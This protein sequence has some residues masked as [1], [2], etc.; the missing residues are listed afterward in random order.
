MSVHSKAAG[1]NRRLRLTAPDST[2]VTHSRGRRTGVAQVRLGLPRTRRRPVRPSN[3][4]P[5]VRRTLILIKVPCSIAAKTSVELTRG[6]RPADHM[7][8]KRTRHRGR[9]LGS[10]TGDARYSEANADA[11]VFAPRNMQATDRP[12]AWSS[13]AIT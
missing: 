7:K 6:R 2:R 3:H 13:Y 12:R 11:V 4:T 8:E 1:E 10:C 9:V 5:A